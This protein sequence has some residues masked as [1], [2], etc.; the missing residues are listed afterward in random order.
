SITHVP[1]IGAGPSVQVDGMAYQC[2]SINYTVSLFITK[3]TDTACDLINRAL[4]LKKSKGKILVHCSVGIL[5]SPM[6][7]A[8]Y[9]MKWNGMMLKEA[10]GQI[11]CIQPQISLNVGFLQQLKSMEM[12]LYGSVF[13][14]VDLLPRWTC[15]LYFL[16]MWRVCQL[17]LG[18]LRP[19]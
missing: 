7:F 19:M 4:A 2:L 13:L 12:E 17:G 8:A 11:I 14:E 18:M 5:G 1:S 6:T 10:L 3:V 16:K 15:W 9:M